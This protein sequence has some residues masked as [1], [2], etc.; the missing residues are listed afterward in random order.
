MNT[1]ASDIRSGVRPRPSVRV[2][3]RTSVA[4][5]E[6]GREGEA[7]VAGD[8]RKWLSRYMEKEKKTHFRSFR[9]PRSLTLSLSPAPRPPFLPPSLLFSTT[10]N[11]LSPQ[12][13]TKTIS[14]PSFKQEAV[15][16]CSLDAAR[17]GGSAQ[18]LPQLPLADG[19]VRGR[20]EVISIWD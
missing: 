10:M 2:R 4:Q 8:G 12:G 14:S 11:R 9:R 6:G 18:R 13:N 16:L 7:E 19:R 20:D 3:P 15:F 17:A 5:R 1:E